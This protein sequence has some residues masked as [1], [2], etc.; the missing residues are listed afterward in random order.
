MRVFVTGATGYIGSA[1]VEALVRAGH[2]VSGLSRSGARDAVLEGLGAHAVRGA[3]GSMG[4][5]TAVLAEQDALVHAAIDYGLGPPADREAIEALL[6][7][8]GTTGR[9]MV[10]VYT[11]GVWVLGDVP[12]PASEA[13]PAD[14][15]PAAVAWRPEHEQRVLRSATSRIATAVIRPGIV[16]GEK[17]GLVSPWFERA[18]K[19]GAAEI[20]GE[21]LN[22]WAFVHRQDL[23]DLYRLVVE[24]RARGIFH[25]VDGA[26]PTVAEAARAASAAAAG[27]RGVVSVTLAKARAT[28]GAVADAL[29][30]DQVVVSKRGQEVGWRPAHPPFPEAAAGAYREWTS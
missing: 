7:A 27:K 26:A 10:V 5:L 11:S 1:V 20:V 17:R 15:P 25:G 12:S 30:M 23:A 24:R 4:S 22:R 6:A 8:A 21:G 18:V 19:Q 9:P 13:T 28:M 2:E 3:L 29:V 14:H 16:Y